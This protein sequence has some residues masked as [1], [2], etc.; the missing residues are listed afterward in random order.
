MST[1]TPGV[2]K[3]LWSLLKSPE[4]GGRFRSVGGRGVAA[5]AADAQS[6]QRA[7]VTRQAARTTQQRTQSHGP[8]PVQDGSSKVRYKTAAIGQQ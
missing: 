2:N 4:A 8:N 6:V 3:E 7:A 1:R 5:R